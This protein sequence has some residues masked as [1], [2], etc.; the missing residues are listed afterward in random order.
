MVEQHHR[1]TP[2]PVQ[3]GL[4]GL[5]DKTVFIRASLVA[6]VLGSVLTVLNQPAAVF[7]T[8]PFDTLPLAL[9]YLTPFVVVVASQLLG[10][11]QAFGDA[12]VI[13]YRRVPGLIATASGNGIPARA[14]AVG[15][16]VGSLNTGLVA[17]VA[18]SAGDG[19]SSLPAAL[20]AQAFILPI[21]FGLLSQAL[22]YW[23]TLAVLQGGS[24]TQNA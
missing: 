19:L 11:R 15:L 16:V 10:K 12:G 4:I 7:G 20:I 14:V 3:P 21:I 23:R 1:R 8:R 6:A 24:A 18:I 5:A 13:G 9:V 2:T 22:A 17:A